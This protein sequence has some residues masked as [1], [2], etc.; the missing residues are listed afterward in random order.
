[1]QITEEGSPR[2][3]LGVEAD[4]L[5]KSRVRKT[6]KNSHEGHVITIE[7]QA[8]RSQDKS[9]YGAETPTI[10]YSEKRVSSPTTNE[11]DQLGQQISFGHTRSH[12]GTLGRTY[13]GTNKT[14]TNTHIPIIISDQHVHNKQR[15]GPLEFKK[16][17]SG[18]PANKGERISSRIGLS[19]KRKT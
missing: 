1:M 13:S 3:N 9:T 6:G 2:K 7:G 14:V 17:T 18:S 12:S 10:T 8:S 15:C 19:R 5:K 4:N 16:E 11:D